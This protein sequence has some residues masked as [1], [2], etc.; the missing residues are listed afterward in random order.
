MNGRGGK[1]LL[2][3]KNI[4]NYNK[5]LLHIGSKRVIIALG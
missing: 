1:Y 2:S 3:G 4:S 5:K